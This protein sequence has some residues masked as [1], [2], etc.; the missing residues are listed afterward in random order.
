VISTRHAKE[1]VFAFLSLLAKTGTPIFILFVAAKKLQID[2]FAIVAFGYL[3]FNL[4]QVVLDLGYQVRLPK[5]MAS[6]RSDFGQWFG[7]TLGIKVAISIFSICVL[8][9][10]FWNTFGDEEGKAAIEFLVSG[11]FSSITLHFLYVLRGSFKFMREAAT[12]VVSELLTLLIVF[13]YCAEGWTVGNVAVGFLLSKGAQMLLAAVVVWP[14]IRPVKI[15]VR[16]GE[17]LTAIPYSI[18]TIVG[19]GFLLVDGIIV[20]GFVNSLDFGVQQMFVR[21]LVVACFVLGPIQIL[22]VSY[23]SKVAFQAPGKMYNYVWMTAGLLSLLSASFLSIYW[24]FD[25]VII[26]VVLGEEFRALTNFTWLLVSIALLRYIAV[27]FG[28]LLSV[29]DGQVKRAKILAAAFLLLVILNFMLVPRFGIAG[30]FYASLIAHIALCSA[31]ML[32]AINR[33]HRLKYSAPD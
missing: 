33:M 31:Y 28:T 10:V 4:T 25:D 18:Q 30:S 6:G 24:S 17:I 21:L 23:F 20:K 14:I 7:V 2:E 32:M 26:N 8:G 9:V 29:S 15:A 27:P 22:L 11:V 5:I 13:I 16:L 12:L 19:A 1:F 3:I